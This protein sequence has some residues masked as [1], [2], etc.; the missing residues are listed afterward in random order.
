MTFGLEYARGTWTALSPIFS[1]GD[2]K[3]GITVSLRRVKFF[4]NGSNGSKHLEIPYISGNSIR[5]YLHRLIFRD[6]I[7]QLGYELDL[8]DQVGKKMFHVL[9]AGGLLESVEREAESGILDLTLKSKL[10]KNVLPFRLYGASY[11]NQIASGKLK[12]SFGLPI[13]KELRDYLPQ[14]IVTESTPSIYS[15]LSHVFQT[16]RDDLKA[17]PFADDDNSKVE[18]NNSVQ[19][20]IKN[21]QAVQMIVE[22]EVFSPGTRFYHEF[23]V[24]DPEPIDL[25]TLSRMIE[26]WQVKPFIGGKSAIGM[27]KLKLEYQMGSSSS[28]PSSSLYHEYISN[29]KKEIIEALDALKL[30]LS[31]R[32]KTNEEGEEGKEKKKRSKKEEEE[33]Q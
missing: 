23:M 22:Q 13:C 10:F 6:F 5:G 15:V 17:T 14:G 24:E 32:R 19:L 7:E 1:G 4:I 26:L 16:R 3:T 8:S 11:A 30:K 25:S 18:N 21:Q 2:E 29:N 27:G 28:P 31:Q 12:V 33:E 9:F 20:E